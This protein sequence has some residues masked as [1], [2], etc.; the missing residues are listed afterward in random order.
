MK[1]NVLVMSEEDLNSAVTGLDK[2]YMN[3]ETAGK[4]IPNQFSNMKKAGLFDMGI[5]TIN[6][7]LN[8]ITSSIFNV[9][10][11]VN[12]HSTEMF[13]MDREL[14]RIAQQIEIPQ[15]F[16]KNNGMQTNTFNDVLLEKLDG[17]SV[18]SGQELGNINEIADSKVTMQALGDITN[19]NGTK[20]EK[21]DES[22]IINKQN[23]NNINNDNEL[24]NQSLDTASVIVKENLRDIN[25]RQDLSEQKVD[26]STIITNKSLNNISKVG[27]LNAQQLDATTVLT[28]T[29]LTDLNTGK[30]LDTQ[31]LDPASSIFKGTLDKVSESPELKS[32]NTDVLGSVNEMAQNAVTDVANNGT[33]N[34]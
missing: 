33:N 28:K 18:N 27:D 24:K 2:C 8:G 1:N 17:K 26:E 30:A 16:V 11:I 29:N 14:A 19:E 10:N 23:V 32:V 25:Q 7:Q 21:I 20:Q 6:K 34:V 12:K 4:N 9:K 31:S 3:T 5:N 13:H 22:T 15:D